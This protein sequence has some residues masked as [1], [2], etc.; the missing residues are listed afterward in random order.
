MKSILRYTAAGVALA[1]FGFAS[2]ASAATAQADAEAQILAALSVTLTSGELNFGNVAES[3]S[4]G[5]VT[6]TTAGVRSC[7][8]GLLCT[9]T[10]TVPSFDIS[11]AP[12]ANVLV[13][14][15]ANTITLTGPGA[16]TMDVDLVSSLSAGAL[17]GT[18]DA[19]FT[20]GGDLD[21][22]AG[23]A[24]GLYTGQ[25]DVEVLYQ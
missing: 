7:T 23:Q 6:V 25:L 15:L 17:D 2:S 8:P 12:N 14:F 21:V 16:A 19:D 10:V 4:G 3:G 18:G 13:S 22:A 20:V 11:G 5:T 24:P 1:T 9:G